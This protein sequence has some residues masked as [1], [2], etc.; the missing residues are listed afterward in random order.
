MFPTF[1]IVHGLVP[2][3]DIPRVNTRNQYVV[4]LVSYIFLVTSEP[5]A[6]FVALAAVAEIQLSWEHSLSEDTFQWLRVLIPE[7]GTSHLM[8]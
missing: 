3:A 4:S 2:E 1:V 5:S 7:L 8:T 6:C